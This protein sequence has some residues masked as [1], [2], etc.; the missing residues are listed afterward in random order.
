[1]FAFAHGGNLWHPLLEQEFTLWEATVGK[2]W[3][4]KNIFVHQ[5]ATDQMR[6]QMKS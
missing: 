6:E 3:K 2:V 4:Y 1:M 5:A